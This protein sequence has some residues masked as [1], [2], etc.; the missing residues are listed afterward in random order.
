MY[1]VSINGTYFNNVQ[2]LQRRCEGTGY[3]ASEE[4]G[5]GALELDT[6][7]LVRNTTPLIPRLDPAQLEASN[8][9]TQMSDVGQH[10]LS[11][12]GTIACFRTSPCKRIVSNRRAFR[13][14]VVALLTTL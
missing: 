9:L 8:R 14:H 3:E 12:T 11:G 10:L 13:T 4:V 2:A 1:D 5:L 6:R 7:S